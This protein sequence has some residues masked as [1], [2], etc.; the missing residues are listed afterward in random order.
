MSVYS[1]S[2]QLVCIMFLCFAPTLQ[3]DVLQLKFGVYTADKPTSTVKQFRPMLNQL[4]QRLSQQSGHTI[5]FKMQ[6]ARS[7]D[8]GVRD[9]VLGLV[10]IARF[11]P[12]SYV[13]AKSQN[14]ALQL[15]A[16][17]SVKGKKTFNGV[18]CVHQDSDIHTVDDLR[19]KRFAFGNEHSTIGRYLSLLYL[20][21]HNI[22]AEDLAAYQYLDR[23]DT[24]AAAVATEQYDAGAVKENTFNKMLAQGKPLR[25]IATFKNIT[26]PWIARAGL[27]QQLVDEIQQA[28]VQMDEPS[29]LSTLGT[30]GFSIVED[31]DYDTIRDAIIASKTFFQS[32]QQ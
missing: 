25:K 3:A 2:L 30:T 6:V 31:S 16:S 11:G 17:E 32:H 21:Q 22:Y 26:K 9:L 13:S 18:I 4:E 19:G 29:A 1:Y 8:E 20:V 24:V 14:E 7:Y 27:N 15:L 5:R 23:H 12:A 28:L 10:D